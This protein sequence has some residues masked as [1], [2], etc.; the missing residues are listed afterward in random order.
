MILKLKLT[1]VV[2][3]VCSI[4]S[5][6]KGS[7]ELNE[8]HIVHSIAV[9]SGQNGGVKLTAEIA[10]LSTGG[11]QPK[12]MQNRT[13]YLTGEGKSLFEA[14]RLM[15]V[16]SDR[17]LLWG[18][19][20]SILFSEDV[21]KL[22]IGKH[23]RAIRQLRQFRN[24]AL[25]Y[26]MKGN[27][28]EALQVTMPNVAITSLALRGL[29]EGA[30]ITALTEKM[31]LIDIYKELVNHYEDL[32][33]PAAQIVTD[34]SEKERRLLQTVG[35]YSFQGDR[36]IGLMKERE[37]K[38]YLR[39]GNKLSG[40]VETLKC[41]DGQTISFENTSNKSRLKVSVDSN[42]RPVIRIEIYADLNLTSLQCKDS[43]VTPGKISDWE[44][45]LN[46]RISEDINQYIDFSQRNKVDL[47][48]VGEIIHRRH[49]KQWKKMKED[50]DTIYASSRFNVE[51][52]SRIDH[53]NFIY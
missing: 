37:T 53:T 11:N 47:L 26:V 40:A 41:D 38:G 48:G 25:V 36:L 9:D 2:I 31:S 29:T 10:K 1:I 28:Y 30:S 21:A 16:K 22:G 42:M 27:A 6:C 43:E 35:I 33:I 52:H 50:W 49:P 45:S 24:S 19:T 13:F 7:E 18:H 5:S 12:G 23:I 39:A 3:V 34:S 14:A 46:E 51:V 20:T 15:R 32:S 4:L 17:T 44:N 8:L